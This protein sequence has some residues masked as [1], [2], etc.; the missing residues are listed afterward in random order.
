[1][2]NRSGVLLTLSVLAVI[3][4]HAETVSGLTCYECYPDRDARRTC[5]NPG[6]ASVKE[7]LVPRKEEQPQAVALCSKIRI[8]GEVTRGCYVDPLGR[9]NINCR[10]NGN[11]VECYCNGNYCN[12]SPH[13]S[14]SWFNLFL[15]L[16]PTMFFTKYLKF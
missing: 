3:F 2:A 8:D 12:G 11:T 6:E 14:M 15:T 1:M 13:I 10:E 4:W 7:C 5:V 16:L 9:K